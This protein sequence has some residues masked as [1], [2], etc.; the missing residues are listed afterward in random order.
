MVFQDQPEHHAIEFQPKR[1]NSDVA[2]LDVGQ[3]RKPFAQPP[4]GGVYRLPVPVIGSGAFD[5]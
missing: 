1:T 3:L 4:I 2:E 5:A